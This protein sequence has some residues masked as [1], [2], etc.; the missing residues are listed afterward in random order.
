ML[1]DVFSSMKISRRLPGSGATKIGNDRASFGKTRAARNGGGG[2]G[3]QYFVGSF[4]GTTFKAE[5]LGPAGVGAVQT[6]EQHSWADW[7][8]DFVD[9]TTFDNAPDG[10][11]TA[12]YTVDLE[13][14]GLWSIGLASTTTGNLLGKINFPSFIAFLQMRWH[15]SGKFIAQ[16]F[17]E[18][19][20]GDF[21]VRNDSNPRELQL[22]TGR[23]FSG[24]GHVC[25]LCGA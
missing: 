6:G 11:Q 7:G 12:F 23:A 20:Q 16:A 14:D 13:T 8:P 17:S 2:S 24:A 1:Y 4:D 18:D 19:H 3:V 15:P 25:G 5:P 10:R 21:Y 9:A 22:R